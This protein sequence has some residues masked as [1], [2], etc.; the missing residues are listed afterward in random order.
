MPLPI[1]C[2]LP[3]I[4]NPDAIEARFFSLEYIVFDME[5]TGI[6]PK[7]DEIIEIAVFR[8]LSIYLR[9]MMRERNYTSSKLRCDLC[10]S[11]SECQP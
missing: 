2:I 1:D 6:D 11:N 7:Q 5:T 10:Q 3:F 4:Q 8:L 9:D